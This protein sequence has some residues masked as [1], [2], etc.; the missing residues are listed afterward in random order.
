MMPF[1]AVIRSLPP[2]ELYH[3]E[4]LSPSTDQVILSATLL[5]AYSVLLMPIQ[6]SRPVSVLYHQMSV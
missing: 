3:S 4:T 2:P 5:Q 6:S 1:S